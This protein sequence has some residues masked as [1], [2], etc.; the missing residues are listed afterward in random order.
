[1]CISTSVRALDKEETKMGGGG[2]EN[3]AESV[4]PLP[5]SFS[6]FRCNAK[7]GIQKPNPK[8]KNQVSRDIKEA[9]ATNL[10]LRGEKPLL[11]YISK[12]LVENRLPLPS[13]F[14]FFFLRFRL[15][16]LFDV[17]KIFKVYKVK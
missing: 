10:P 4:L 9:L 1:M 3:K 6:K 7:N 13:F 11:R 2:S 5:S 15:E 16:R 12:L 14:L 17:S 8:D